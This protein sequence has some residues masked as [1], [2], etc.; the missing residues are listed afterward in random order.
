MPF[1]VQE[2][3]AAIKRLKNNK[4]AAAVDGILGEFLKHCP[5]NMYIAITQ[6]CNLTLDTGIVPTD[7]CIGFICPIFKKKEQRKNPDNCHGITLLSCMGKLFT[8]CL[9]HK[10]CSYV[11]CQEIIGNEQAGFKSGSST[12]DHIYALHT[13]IDVYLN[14][15]KR[16]YCALIYY[17][18]AFDYVDRTLLRQRI[19]ESNVNGKLFRVINNIYDAAK[20]CIK[21]GNN[22]LEIFH[23]HN[24]VRQGE[25]LSPVLFA[26]LINVFKNMC[27]HNTMEYIHV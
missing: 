2:V 18:K 9:N 24:G 13:R 27:L 16:L 25:N 11:E 1:T 10:L 7:W 21:V 3:T 20:S 17:K 15:K 5:N 8:S 6:L 26:M 19:L 23:C 22:L 14:K 4:S 12:I